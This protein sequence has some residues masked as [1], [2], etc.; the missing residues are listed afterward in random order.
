MWYHS[1]EES[2]KVFVILFV[3]WVMGISCVTV[4]SDPFYK[5]ESVVKNMFSTMT[6]EQKSE[7]KR[8]EPHQSDDYS[9]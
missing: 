5:W 6:F 4:C 1:Q 8:L 2:H 3:K 7:V 9:Y